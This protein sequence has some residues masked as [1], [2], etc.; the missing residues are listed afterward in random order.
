MANSPRIL[1]FSGSARR[2]SLNQTLLANVVESTR[3]A[4]GE[5]TVLAVHVLSRPLYDGDL[6]DADGM[7]TNAQ[8]F[9]DL[10]TSH[11][12]LLIA[13]P[14]NNSQITPVLKNAID[15]ATRADEI[16][17]IGKAT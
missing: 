17:L 3:A 12:A 15:W 5:V 9:V 14:E 6:E 7:P 8:K 11:H 1:A 13:A 2:E 16:P 4:G 10:I